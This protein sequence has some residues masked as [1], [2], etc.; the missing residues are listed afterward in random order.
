[1]KNRNLM[2]SPFA[3]LQSRTG[4]AVSD[5]TAAL[6]LLSAPFTIALIAFV[7]AV[8]TTVLGEMDKGSARFY[9]AAF[10]YTFLISSVMA[11]PAYLAGYGWYWWWTKDRDD[12]IATGLWIAPLVATLFA[13]FPAT[14]F[15]APGKLGDPA[16]NPFQIYL[17]MAALTLVFGYIWALVVRVILR[18]WRKI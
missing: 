9:T 16:V 5:R 7:L 14:L 17:L 10:S 6:A 18:L 4:L 13:W 3:P 12:R 1:M 15:P 2:A 11:L 8:L